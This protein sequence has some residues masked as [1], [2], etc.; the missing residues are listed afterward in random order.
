MS[1]ISVC[2]ESTQVIDV[3]NVSE[4]HY[5]F[6][7]NDISAHKL[8]LIVRPREDTKAM[9]FLMHGVIL[10]R[11]RFEKLV[12]RRR[13]PYRKLLKQGNVFSRIGDD[14]VLNSKHTGIIDCGS[15]FRASELDTNSGY[16]GVYPMK[17]I[18]YNEE[19]D[20]YTIYGV[21]G[22]K[23]PTCDYDVTS[24]RDYSKIEIKHSK[25]DEIFQ[26]DGLIALRL[27]F[28]L[29]AS[30]TD[31]GWWH[32]ITRWLYRFIKI[33]ATGSKESH[34]I[35]LYSFPP[36]I[37]ACCGAFEINRESLRQ[38]RLYLD[39]SVFLDNDLV[40]ERLLNVPDITVSKIEDAKKQATS[41]VWVFGDRYT[42][43]DIR[44]IRGGVEP[45]VE[46][47]NYLMFSRRKDRRLHINRYHVK[48][49][50]DFTDTVRQFITPPDFHEI[51]VDVDFGLPRLK[52]LF[53]RGSWGVL[54][55]IFGSVFAVSFASYSVAGEDQ[56]SIRNSIIFALLAVLLFIIL[57]SI[58]KMFWKTFFKKR[59]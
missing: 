17:K 11:G 27:I 29:K 6:S 13:S 10:K 4:C 18:K 55:G 53:T 50:R 5:L 32:K 43:V 31:V 42:T 19:A 3:L 44:G 47:P 28:F 35:H 21:D 22:I 25:E 23:V 58:G 16:E 15:S 40:I 20:T 1:L 8:E 26:K 34:E 46:Q 54:I 45:E 24:H 9:K 33:L 57:F 12:K 37:E 38:S 2:G 41:D 49:G 51:A 56:S 48:I 36:E 59:Y 52:G 14:N 7:R 39:A 30:D